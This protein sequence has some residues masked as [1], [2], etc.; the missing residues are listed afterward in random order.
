MLRFVA[1]LAL[2]L[3]F[4]PSIIALSLSSLEATPLLVAD[5]LLCDQKLKT[6]ATEGEE[7]GAQLAS[8]CLE[9]LSTCTP[10]HVNSSLPSCAPFISLPS[11]SPSPPAPLSA[12]APAVAHEEGEEERDLEKRWALN[13]IYLRQSRTRHDAARK[14]FERGGPTRMEKISRT[15]GKVL[16]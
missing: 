6:L 9:A 14:M 11:S 10:E 4:L 7:G 15:T 13:P 16:R 3:P 5:L 8:T 1:V 2:V 12:R